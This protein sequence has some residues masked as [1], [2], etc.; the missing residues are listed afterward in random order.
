MNRYV[1]AYQIGIDTIELVDCRGKDILDAMLNNETLS[2]LFDHEAFQQFEPNNTDTVERISA[3][4][5]G[6][7][8]SFNFVDLGPVPQNS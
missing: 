7:G 1:V 4:L 3:Y 6:V 5:D 8:V 2:N